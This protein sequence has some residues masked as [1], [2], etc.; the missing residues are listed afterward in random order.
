MRGVG[1]KKRKKKIMSFL[2]LKIANFRDIQI[3]V[4]NVVVFYT[5]Y[6]I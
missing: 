5:E 2:I 4:V 3:Y 1:R 6:V